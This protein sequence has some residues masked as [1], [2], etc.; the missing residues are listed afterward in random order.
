M[1]CLC[2]SNY[3]KLL[4]LKFH[5]TDQLPLTR[6][7]PLTL[8]ICVCYCISVNMSSTRELVDLGKE[9]GYEGDS[10]REFVTEEQNRERERHR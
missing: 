10:L 5:V 1:P 6:S 2:L 3:F 9:F 8:V 7:Y 4:I